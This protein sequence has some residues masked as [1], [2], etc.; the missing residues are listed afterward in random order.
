LLVVGVRRSG[1]IRQEDLRL[2][3]GVNGLMHRNGLLRRDRLS[4]ALASQRRL[5]QTARRNA[6]AIVRRTAST[7]TNGVASAEGSKQHPDFL[8]GFVA[9]ILA[10]ILAWICWLDFLVDSLFA[11]TAISSSRNFRLRSFELSCVR[12]L[13]SLA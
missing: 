9:W 6:R 1:D 5:D 8:P 13:L 3:H 10:W 11:T 2:A 7:A 4:A 12:T